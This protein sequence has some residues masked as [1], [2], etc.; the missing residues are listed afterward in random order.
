MGKKRQARESALQVLFQ[1]E[2]NDSQVDT[3]LL[4][5]W[6]DRKAS[7][8]V[9]EDTTRLVKGVVDHKEKIDA[10]I[11]A[12]SENWRLSRMVLLDRNIL[13]IATYELFFGETLAPAI[14]INEAIEVA[15]KYSGEQSAT[16]INGILDALPKRPEA[17]AT[18]AKAEDDE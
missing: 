17:E 13:R 8:E 5:Y 4:Q 7:L 14:V 18:E 1:L 12:G 9:K 11:Q 16:F 3:I 2:F 10:L 6:S 15:K